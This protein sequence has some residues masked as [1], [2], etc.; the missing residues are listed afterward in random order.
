MPETR[1]LRV[2]DIMREAH[3]FLHYRTEEQQARREREAA[4]DVLKKHLTA[5]DED[6][7]PLHAR[8]DGDGNLHLDFEAPLEIGGTRYAGVMARRSVS[9]RIDVKAAEALAKDKGVYDDVFPERVVREFDEDGLYLAN[10]K[11]LLS[12]DDLDGLVAERV[13]YAMW[14]EQARDLP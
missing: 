2:S 12:D 5:R 7:L 6:G 9:A 10:Q 1:A 13:D 4:R 14:P 11:G 8:E 3:R